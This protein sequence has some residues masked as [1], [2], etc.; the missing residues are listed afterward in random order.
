MTR[1]VRA[2]STEIVAKL[3]SQVYPSNKLPTQQRAVNGSN[4]SNSNVT[5]QTSGRSATP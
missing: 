1:A 3:D 2:G 4:G 5:A